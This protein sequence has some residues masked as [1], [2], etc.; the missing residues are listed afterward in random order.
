MSIEVR[1]VC[2]V[3]ATWRLT[4]LLTSEDGPGDIV[5][6]LRA[7]LGHS[8]LGR[9]M[10]CFYCL[11]I[12]IAAPLTPFVSTDPLEMVFAWLA[13]SGGACLLERG[14]ATGLLT[15]AAA[16]TSREGGIDELLWTAPPGDARG[17]ATP[18]PTRAGTVGP[19]GVADPD[20]ISW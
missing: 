1:I 13:L 18:G 12:W 2:G 8:T 6:R 15:H 5:V 11:S 17:D 14:T 4:H 16:R 9:A 20:R 19:A 10:D 7:V 3:L